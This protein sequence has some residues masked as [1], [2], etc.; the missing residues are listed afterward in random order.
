MVYA[1]ER[2]SEAI[3]PS[4][5]A[6]NE[7]SIDLT[8]FQSEAQSIDIAMASPAP[9]IK[10]KPALEVEPE[11]ALEIEP[12]PEPNR[13]P[14]QPTAKPATKPAIKPA[15]KPVNTA[16]ATSSSETARTDGVSSAQRTSGLSS[17]INPATRKVSQ[18]EY[19]GSAP[20]PV[21]PARSMQ[22]GDQGFVVVRVVI[23]RW[24]Q[25]SSA[26][27]LQ[28]SGSTALD[29]SAVLAVRTTRFKPYQEDG[30][31]MRATADI[32]FNFILKR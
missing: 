27:I 5:G 13:Q 20:R 2:T 31:A 3:S 21:Y 28:S 32:P 18:L 19:A 8:A 1:F 14:R 9:S 26:D 16:M 25:V 30:I 29:E 11:P 22:S 4:T 23:D 17:S 6:A 24:G 12:E 15:T 7:I 10:S